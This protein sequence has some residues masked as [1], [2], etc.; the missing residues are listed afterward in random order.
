MIGQSGG[1]VTTTTPGYAAPG[2]I[3]A[4]MTNNPAYSSYY[5]APGTQTVPTPGVATPGSTSVMP[6]MAGYNSINPMGTTMAS[7]LLLRPGPPDALCPGTP[8]RD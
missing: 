2:T 8:R 6:G 4:A 7:R 1:T 5:Y 3:N